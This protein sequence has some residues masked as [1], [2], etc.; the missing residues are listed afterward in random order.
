LAGSADTTA[1]N[2][3]V[4][5]EPQ[6]NYTYDP[7]TST[8]WDSPAASTHSYSISSQ[9]TD[10]T[11]LHIPVGDTESRHGSLLTDSVQAKHHQ[12]NRPQVDDTCVNK[13]N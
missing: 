5:E 8:Q 6:Y 7:E 4:K 10:P 9:A 11:G 2:I 3:F 13:G 1:P 12:A